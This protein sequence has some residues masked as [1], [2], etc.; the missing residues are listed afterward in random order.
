MTTLKMQ[1]INSLNMR[2]WV[3]K[4]V[5]MEKLELTNFLP[6]FKIKLRKRISSTKK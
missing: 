1:L 6:I 4:N 2:N 3:I 5:R